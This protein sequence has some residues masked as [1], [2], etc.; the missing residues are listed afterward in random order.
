M[1]VGQPVTAALILGG[2]GG[3]GGLV[4]LGDAAGGL[5]LLTPDDGALVAQYN[6]GGCGGRRPWGQGYWAT[7]ERG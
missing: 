3:G 4:V 1:E 2:R 7:A 6:T 5:H